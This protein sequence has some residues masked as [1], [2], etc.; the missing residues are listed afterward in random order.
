MSRCR[1]TQIGVAKLKKNEAPEVQIERRR[2][3]LR[4]SEV[5]ARQRSIFQFGDND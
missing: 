3:S 5:G 1:K 2:T 4:W